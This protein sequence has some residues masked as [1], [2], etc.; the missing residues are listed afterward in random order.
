M[1]AG[2]AMAMSVGLTAPAHAMTAADLE[3]LAGDIAWVESRTQSIGFAATASA[4]PESLYSGMLSLELDL[5]FPAV[6]NASADSTD[7]NTYIM[8]T[9]AMTARE[10]MILR[11]CTIAEEAAPPASLRR[12]GFANVADRINAVKNAL[13]LQAPEYRP[14]RRELGFDSIAQA[15]AAAEDIMNILGDYQP[16]D[17]DVD[18]SPWY[19]HS[20]LMVT[21][22]NAVD[23][24]DFYSQNA[25]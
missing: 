17:P 24:C 10:T 5:Q 11:A 2:A 23:A 16:M 14:S 1:T 7:Y 9:E 19:Y 25:D 8:A 12:V 18:A 3:A 21:W 6:T 20:L 15:A 22:Q 4:M 13:Q